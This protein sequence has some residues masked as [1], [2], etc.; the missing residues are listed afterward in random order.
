MSSQTTLRIFAI[1]AALALV[2]AIVAT[3]TIIA[4]S[5]FAVGGPKG[6]KNYG[7]CKADFSGPDKVCKKFHTGSG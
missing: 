4:N 1:A 7:K 3:T 2:T 6:E 5:A